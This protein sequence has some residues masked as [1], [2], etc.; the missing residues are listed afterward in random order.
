MKQRLHSNYIFV[1]EGVVSC[2]KCAKETLFK[3]LPY[4]RSVADGGRLSY[5]RKCRYAQVTDVHY[6]TPERLLQERQIKIRKRVSIA[7][8]SKANLTDYDLPNGYLFALWTAQEGKCFY[9]KADLIFNRNSPYHSKLSVDCVN[10]NLGYV[11][12]NVVLTS[13][14][15]NT[16]KSDLSLDELEEYLPVWFSRIHNHLEPLNGKMAGLLW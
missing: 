2:S 10:P 13:N 11:V 6:E 8:R 7:N 3:D 5:C 12:G 4:V 9:T 15:I 14:R 16:M 1:S